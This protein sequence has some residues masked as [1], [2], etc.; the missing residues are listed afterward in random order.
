MIMAPDFSPYIK[1]F[2]PVIN[3]QYD[4]KNLRPDSRVT[5]CQ[6]YLIYCKSQQPEDAFPA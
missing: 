1:S 6:S 5:G 3:R 2:T 4:Y